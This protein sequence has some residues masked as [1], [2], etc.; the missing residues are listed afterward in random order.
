MAA[1]IN[2]TAFLTTAKNGIYWADNVDVYVIVN[3]VSPVVGYQRGDT[4][5]VTM[6]D[7]ARQAGVSIKTVSRVVNNQSEIS[8][9]TRQ[10]VLAVIDELSYRPNK[11]AQGLVTQRT[12]AVGLVVGDITNPFFPEVA[13]GVIDAAQA[14][15]YNVFLCNTDGNVEQEL[16]T[17]ESL[18]AH[19]VDGIIVYPSY[20]SET[21]LITIAKA[22]H[23]VVVINYAFD[24]PGV[25]NLMVDHRRGARLAVDYLAGKGHSRIGMLTGVQQPSLG[26]MRRIQ[27]FREGLAAL[28]LPINDSWIMPS[29][30]PTFESGYES[31]RQLLTQ[32]PE[33]TA[34]FAYNDLLALGAIRACHD[35]GRAIPTDCAIVGFDDIQWAATASPSLTTIRI[36]KY[37][38]GQQAMTR[39]LAM[40]AEPDGVFPTIYLD[41]ELVARESA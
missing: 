41:V 11:L 7:V 23:P 28:S 32:H 22:F 20:D 36:K 27:G 19:A 30:G 10:R 6:R 15:N 37:E 4:V 34:I 2:G 18:A 1:S 35:L 39:L 33:I 29:Q 8:A 40:L 9:E 5:P 13:R 38:L 12:F 31:A 3:V 24:H 17:L 16:R 21:N 14:E 26:R 25:S